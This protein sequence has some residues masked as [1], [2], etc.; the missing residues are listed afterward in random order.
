MSLTLVLCHKLFSGQAVWMR[1]LVEIVIAVLVYFLCVFML[2][3]SAYSK[4]I[5]MIKKE[6]DFFDR[7]SMWRDVK[8]RVNFAAHG[9]R[10]SERK[11]LIGHGSYYDGNM[12]YG[13]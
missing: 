4:I 12:Q 3:N 5:R 7:D 6:Y 1:L 10:C 11:L 8:N 13:I 2:K 9:N